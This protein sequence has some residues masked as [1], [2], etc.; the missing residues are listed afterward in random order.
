M[1]GC[2]GICIVVVMI[3]I[4]DRK[5]KADVLV[6]HMRE[7]TF[8]ARMNFNEDNQWMNALNWPTYEG[9]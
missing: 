5:S 3:Q 1:R 7:H 6:E 8:L 2:G 4:L 9:R